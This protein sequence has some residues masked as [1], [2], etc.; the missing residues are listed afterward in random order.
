MSERIPAW[1]FIIF[2]LKIISNSKYTQTMKEIVKIGV[3]INKHF[4]KP[5]GGKILHCGIVVKSMGIL[6]QKA[7]GPAY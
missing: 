1:R 3:S 2:L 4:K 7:L 6:S 5:S